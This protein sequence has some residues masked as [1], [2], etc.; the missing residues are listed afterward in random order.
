MGKQLNFSAAEDALRRRNASALK[1]IS[2]RYPGLEINLSVKRPLGEERKDF[3]GVQELA[4]LAVVEA[5]E[6]L[7]ELHAYLTAKIGMLAKI[8]LVAATGS[9]LSSASLLVLVLGQERGQIFAASVTLFSTVFGLII[10]YKEDFT[11]GN[12]SLKKVR[13]NMSE[14]T[15]KIATLTA[16]LRLAESLGDSEEIIGILQKTNAVFGEVQYVRAKLGLPV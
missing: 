8:R 15:R 6:D 10:T 13:D 5:K 3:S 4:K 1:D 12:E 7:S 2:D 14:E 11:G 16:E 9:T